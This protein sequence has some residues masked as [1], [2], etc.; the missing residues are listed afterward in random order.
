MYGHLFN[1]FRVNPF[2]HRPPMSGKTVFIGHRFEISARSS[3][4][5]ARN[6]KCI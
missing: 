6:V 3:E 2:A 4:F 5:F 1:R